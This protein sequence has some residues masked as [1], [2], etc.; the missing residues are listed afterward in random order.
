M[1]DLNREETMVVRAGGLIIGPPSA[2]PGFRCSCLAVQQGWASPP[3]FR[4]NKLSSWN[5]AT[6]EI[7][8]KHPAHR[9]VKG[10]RSGVSRWPPM[11]KS[12]SV[13]VGERGGNEYALTR[14]GKIRVPVQACAI[15]LPNEK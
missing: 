12:T 13:R 15:P 7:Q 4:N 5:S 3:I 11:R 10:E 9:K 2:S 1:A 6:L 14:M 8:T